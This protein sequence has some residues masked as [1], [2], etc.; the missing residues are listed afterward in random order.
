MSRC[1]E[2]VLPNLP[3]KK[4]AEEKRLRAPSRAAQAFHVS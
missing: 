2:A 1:A 4:I 3:H